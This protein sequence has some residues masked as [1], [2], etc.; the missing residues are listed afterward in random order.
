M[1][2]FNVWS[3]PSAFSRSCPFQS[4]SMYPALRRSLKPKPRS[5]QPGP[6]NAIG[7][8]RAIKLTRFCRLPFDCLAILLPPLANIIGPLTL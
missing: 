5:A 2:E 1:L 6:H 8:V 4:A 7:H 3:A